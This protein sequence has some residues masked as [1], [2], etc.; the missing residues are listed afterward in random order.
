MNCRSITLLFAAIV[1]MITVTD[2]TARNVKIDTD[3]SSIIINAENGK[4]LHHLYYGSKISETDAA[5][6]TQALG[7]GNLAYP[8]YG[9]ITLP[10]TAIAMIQPD[11][12]MTLDLV[13][14]NVS[15]RKENGAN[16]TTFTLKDTYY[17]IIVTV[18]Y[19]TW[20]GENVMETWTEIKNNGKKKCHSHQIC[21][22]PSSNPRWRRVAY[23][24]L[25]KCEK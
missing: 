25:W 15:S 11:G 13:V 23:A 16:I 6:I 18:N 21:L 10:E 9:M 2:L 12:N 7:K 5:N 14:D 3:N 1:S 24:F 19:R 22:R 20:Q 8:D 17:P 4:K